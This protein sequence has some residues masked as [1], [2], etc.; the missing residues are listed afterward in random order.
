MRNETVVAIPSMDMV[1]M[2]FAQSLAMLE[3]PGPT[4]IA[5]QINSLIYNARNA[6]AAEAIR[7][8]A[9]RIFWLDSDMVVPSGTL[10]HLS[11]LMDELGD[12]VILTG[13]YFRRV[14]P[15]NPVLYDKLDFDE[16]GNC[17]W[18]ELDE[19][20]DDIFEVKGCGFG[21]VLAPTQAFIDVREKFG[22][23]FSPLNGTGEDLS[24][25][26]RARQC[27]WKIMCDPRIVLGH[28]GHTIIN[29]AYWENY[30]A[31]L[32]QEGQKDG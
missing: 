9:S 12:K 2:L 3:K 14:P 19:I 16:E 23:M 7:R 28:Y 15:Y 29:R 5:S 25:C 4:S 8:E 26:W 17:I 31:F 22:N 13:A 18:S 6:L 27:G 24:F 21:C 11:K 1:P 10:V 20:P 30:S 32:A